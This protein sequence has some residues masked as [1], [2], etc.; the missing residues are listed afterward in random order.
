MNVLGGNL[1][2]ASI[3]VNTLT[4]GS[5]VTVTIQPIPGGPL[6]LSDNLQSVAEP[7]TLAFLGVNLVGLLAYAWRRRASRCAK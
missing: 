4:I 7:S 1:T 2:A 3:N 6:A 5:G